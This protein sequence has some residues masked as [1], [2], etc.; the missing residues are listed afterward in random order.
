MIK[1]WTRNEILDKA[2]ELGYRYEIEMHGC[3]QSIVRVVIDLF[4]MEEN[5]F[6]AA[7]TTSG[8]I[9]NG[10]TGPC[11]GFLGSVIA[12]GYFFG[13]DL[14]HTNIRGSKFKDRALVN[15]IREKYIETYGSIICWDVQKSVFGR[16]FN[17]RDEEE[18]I[19]FEEAGSHIDKCPSIIG[20][21]ARWLVEMLLDEGAPL[22][23]DLDLEKL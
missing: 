18:K 19:D 4:E 11:G 9:A 12:L 8:G 10:G 7:S 20:K 21:A 14:E 2:Y 6:K 23:K 15:K 22:R 3:A 5:V 17:L 1:E 16:S 13:R